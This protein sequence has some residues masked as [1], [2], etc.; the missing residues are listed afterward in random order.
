MEPEDNNDY[1]YKLQITYFIN[2]F[3]FY[4]VHKNQEG[5]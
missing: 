3:E 1:S 4:I 5:L 2:I